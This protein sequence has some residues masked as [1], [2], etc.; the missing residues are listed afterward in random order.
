VAAPVPVP[1]LMCV[2]RG[3]CW[4]VEG[5]DEVEVEPDCPAESVV[6]ASYCTKVPVVDLE[7]DQQTGQSP[8]GSEIGVGLVYCTVLY[9]TVL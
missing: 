1:D 7:V 3:V 2:G 5:E 9:C 4:A 8:P 6:E